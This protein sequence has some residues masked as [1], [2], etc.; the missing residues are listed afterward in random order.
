MGSTLVK[1][2]V[3]PKTYC[4]YEQMLRNHIIKAIPEEHWK[5]KELDRVPGLGPTVLTKLTRQEVQ[6]YLNE[7][8]KA[9][10]SPSL[11]RYLRTVMRIG[12]NQALRDEL[13]ARN[14][15][16]LAK[17]PR[18]EKREVLPFNPEQA[19]RFLKAAQDHRLEALFTVGL[20]VGLRSGECS[21]LRWKEDVDVAAGTITVHHTLQR[22]KGDGL[23][24]VPPKSDNPGGPSNFPQSA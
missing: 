23:V 19:G 17:P 12:L 13:I 21:A 9:G 24:L 16:A 8:L 1:P 7:K 22:R 10:N 6:H 14:P 20:A 15:A 3:R 18:V 5:E 2:S 11:V 4:S